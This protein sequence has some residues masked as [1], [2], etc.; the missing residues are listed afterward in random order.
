MKLRTKIQ[1]FSSLF[2]FVLILLVN[3]AIYFSFY[4]MSTDTEL[5][6]LEIVTNDMM[7]ALYANPNVDPGEL[8][9]AYLPANGLI[10]VILDSDVPI[11]EQ[12]RS[13]DYL[14]LPW[15]FTN[16]ESK[17]IYSQKGVA[18]IVV[19]EKPMI[20]AVGEYKGEIVT[21]QVSNQL[22]SL[23]E[24]LRTLLFVLAIL[25]IVVLLPVILGSSVLSGFLLRP[26]QNLIQTMK[27]NIKQNEWEKI[28]VRTKSH[29]EMY[30]MEMTF[31]E[32]IEHLKISYEKQEMF[33]SDASHEL[34][35][36]IQIIKSYAQLLERRGSLNPDLFKESI[37]AI[38]S[39]AD[40]MKKLV[41]QMLAM[42]KNQ[43]TKRL[44]KVN[45]SGLL[46]ETINTFHHAYDRK[47]NFIKET[48][49]LFVKGNRDQLEQV[50]YILI[51]NAFKY[52]EDNIEVNMK[53]I[54]DKVI[55]EVTDFGNGMKEEDQSRIFDRFYRVDK[56]RSRDT[57]GT[58]LGLSIAKS[59]VEAHNGD[60][61]VESKLGEGSTFML[62]LKSL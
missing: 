2:M 37:E 17:N 11:I 50:V 3:T 54:D 36:P 58:G 6:E 14:T 51:D 46:D 10:R 20:W 8:M 45:F 16:A 55:L 15:K 31:N 1:V 30:E 44:E 29:D 40:R 12:T 34:K 59:I 18:D 32:M 61:S 7:E 62:T 5:E 39:E 13:N 42:A 4:K 28:D 23:H 33:V 35:T 26:I 56:A 52:S 48:T 60:I 22:L 9:K 21:V 49:N 47:I 43:E 24:T 53:K 25:S 41:E 38:D 27:K 19:I 57:G